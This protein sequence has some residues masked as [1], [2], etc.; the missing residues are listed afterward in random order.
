MSPSKRILVLCTGNSA[1]SQMA[2]GLLR[3]ESDGTY[4]V[5]SAG[6]HPGSVQPEAIAVM[7]EVGIDIAHHRSKSLDE[8]TGQSFDTIIT[9]CSK[10]SERCPSFPGDP[11][12]IAWDFN[13]PAVV[14]G[15]ERRL[16][17]Y[18]RVRDELLRRIR[19]FLL[20]QKD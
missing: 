15:E 5:F 19:L 6:T 2:E 20:V 13:D 9:V 8:F 10:A 3:E 4:E 18:R 14:E 1:R 7:A 16:L 11:E 17:A 12:R